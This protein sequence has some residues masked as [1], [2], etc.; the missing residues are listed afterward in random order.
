M[1]LGDSTIAKS[2]H[3][4]T[5]FGATSRNK[6]DGN[7]NDRTA[8]SLSIPASIYFKLTSPVVAFTERSSAESSWSQTVT[9]VSSRSDLLCGPGLQQACR[10]LNPVVA[11]RAISRRGAMISL[12]G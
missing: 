1:W 5:T 9:S 2:R 4:L 7:R 3:S 12:H 10:I 6:V 8:S 11:V